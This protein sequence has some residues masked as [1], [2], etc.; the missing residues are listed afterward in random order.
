MR[1][2]LQRSTVCAAARHLRWLVDSVGHQPFKPEQAPAVL[3]GW[4]L[5]TNPSN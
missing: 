2:G 3:D 5:S 1:F 4:R